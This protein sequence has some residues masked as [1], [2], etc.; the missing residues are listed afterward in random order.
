M[1]NKTQL[2]T[3][4]DKLASLIQEL[5]NKAAGGGSGGSVETCTVTI[6]ENSGTSCRCFYTAYENGA[7]IHKY[8]YLESMTTNTLENVVCS[9]LITIIYNTNM[10]YVT[11]GGGAEDE[12]GFQF[13]GARVYIGVSAPNLAGATGTIT[14][15]DED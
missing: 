2:S 1:S 6:T 12:T 13:D 10:P 4:N 5:A 3:N 7:Q 11:F 15:V 9:S 8:W 14:L